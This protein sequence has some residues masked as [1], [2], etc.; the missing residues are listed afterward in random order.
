MD[1]QQPLYNPLERRVICSDGRERKF[2]AYTRNYESEVKGFIKVKG[3][4]V[5]GKAVQK[6]KHLPND[7][8]FVQDR[9]KRNGDLLPKW[10]PWIPLSWIEWES[11]SPLLKQALVRAADLELND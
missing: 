7:W 6:Y 1:E 10:F 5:T 8:Y 2:R 11:T 9:D 4:S 3:L